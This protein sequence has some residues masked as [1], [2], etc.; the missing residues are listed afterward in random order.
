MGRWVVGTQK[1]F[2]HIERK[3]WLKTNRRTMVK[4]IQRS[5]GDQKICSGHQTNKNWNGYQ[6]INKKSFQNN[7]YLSNSWYRSICRN[8]HTQSWF[9]LK[10]YWLGTHL[11]WNSFHHSPCPVL[12]L[13]VWPSEM[14]GVGTAPGLVRLN[15]TWRLIIRVPIGP[16][17]LPLEY[18]WRQSS[19][20]NPKVR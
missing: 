8:P 10:S 14:R 2:M 15:L 5:S 11:Q 9:K 12:N 18:R 3:H 17:P 16:K 13:M 19:Y 4:T 6:S 7:G 1:R 20:Q